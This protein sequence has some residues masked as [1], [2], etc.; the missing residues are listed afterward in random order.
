[1]RTTIDQFAWLSF[2]SAVS[3]FSSE[4]MSDSD[5]DVGEREAACAIPL[6]YDPADATA[7]AVHPP[8]YVMVAPRGVDLTQ[9]SFFKIPHPRHG[10][11][12]IFALNGDTGDLYEL[13]EHQPQYSCWF[14]DD[15]V[16]PSSPL[17]VLT[18]FNPEYFALAV[19]F[20]SAGEN[21]FV[22]PMD[23]LERATAYN[24]AMPLVLQRR[25]LAALPLLC[26][27]RSFGD[28]Q[29]V[30]YSVQA[31]ARWFKQKV[32][33]LKASPAAK[34]LC[35]GDRQRENGDTTKVATGA[36]LLVTD[37]DAL[38]LK[39]SC[40]L[41]LDLVPTSLHKPLQDAAGDVLENESSH[42]RANGGSHWEKRKVDENDDEAAPVKK[43]AK[44]EVSANLV[45]LMKAGPPKGTPSI[46]NFF[47]KKP[48]A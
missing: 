28:E 3:F 42:V 16:E 30:Q 40:Q 34:V 45:K 15:A 46:A 22:S 5:S 23:M 43:K 48:T 8:K 4:C 13:Q 32:D 11:R 14:I 38:L 26:Q 10:V 33:T 31:A 35:F 36:A 17:F 9:L 12:A 2:S 37:D 44:L 18:V 29:F 1:M 27:T 24:S 20:A 7:E 47:A 21:R 39:R 25:V 19:A 41:L 6:A